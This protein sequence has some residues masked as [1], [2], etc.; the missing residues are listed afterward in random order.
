MEIKIKTTDA[1]SNLD[2]AYKS[3]KRGL[4]AT[5]DRTS[6][7]GKKDFE[8]LK[9]A[10]RKFIQ[11]DDFSN[12]Y[13]LETSHN[14]V[15]FNKIYA[16]FSIDV[17]SH[18]H[19]K[20]FLI[21]PTGA[22]K[23]VIPT[24][25]SEEGDKHLSTYKMEAS[26][27]GIAFPVRSEV[28]EIVLTPL[29]DK[30]NNIYSLVKKEESTKARI[31]LMVSEENKLRRDVELVQ[32]RISTLKKESEEL[33]KTLNYLQGQIEEKEGKVSV[34]D[35][36]ISALVKERGEQDKLLQEVKS[37]V[38]KA[39]KQNIS[40]NESI[41]LN[42]S[43]ITGLEKSVSTLKQEITELS[44]QKSLFDNELSGF[45]AEGKSQSNIYIFISF[46]VLYLLTYSVCITIDRGL[47]FLDYPKDQNMLDILISR[48]PL[49]VGIS[50]IISMCFGF[51]YFMI[52]QAIKINSDRMK[53]IKASIIAKDMWI[54]SE[55]VDELS[56][57]ERE[58]LRQQAKLQLISKIFHDVSG[59]KEQDTKLLDL[60][61][62]TLS[63]NKK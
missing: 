47:D 24:Y 28:R 3:V 63:S 4:L 51:A 38:D 14:L 53:F 40:M 41:D 49:T 55:G 8:R 9:N 62:E 29:S 22:L 35:S 59:H 60:L 61:I 15:V 7:Q 25:S 2:I 20:I 36:Q 21:F 12:I 34:L 54:A 27:I 17:L 44:Q 33:D 39:E 5:L 30:V 37:E 11:I 10:I 52:N 50:L 16:V 1:L 31:N 43:T 42:K 13:N 57:F 48:I 18:Q 45:N 58:K 46:I 6:E 26:V 32:G 56:A 23:E 19:G